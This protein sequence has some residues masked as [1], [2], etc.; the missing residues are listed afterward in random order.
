MNKADLLLEIGCEEIPARFVEG[1]RSQLAEKTKEWLQEN[2]IQH[3]E[4]KTYA[5]PRRL[6]VYVEQVATQQPDKEEEVRGPAKRIALSEQGEWSKAAQGFARKQ[7]IEPSAFTFK[8]FKGETYVYAEVHQQG[9]QTHVLLNAGVRQI[10]EGLHF[11]KTMRWGDRRMRFIRP[12][13]WLVCMLGEEVIAAEWADCTATNQTKGHR[14][15]GTATALN[16]PRE[17]VERLRQQWVVVDVEERRSLIEKQLRQ[18]ESEQGWHIPV[19]KGLLEEV[20]HLVEYPTALFGRYDESFLN[21][22]KEVLI[23]TMR[24]HQRYFPVETEDGH[25][26]PY[27]VTI[28]NGDDTSLDIV[29]RGNEKVLRARL[30][31]AQFFYEEDQKMSIEAGVEKLSQVVF[32]E[33][34]GTIGDK[35]KRIQQISAELAK[36]MQMDEKVQA[37]LARAAAI[38]KFD[39][40]TL[41]IGEFPELEGLMGEDYARK[42]GEEAEVAQAIREHYLPRAAGDDLPESKIAALIGLADRM[43]TI[44]A[45]FGIGLQPTGSQ[46]PY[47][48]RRRAAGVIQLLLDL[49]SF[50]LSLRQLN[51]VAIKTLVQHNLLQVPVTE[52]KTQIH[53]FFSARQKTVLQDEHIRYDVIEAVLQS[54]IC[55]PG[56][57]RAKAHILMQEVKQP[58]FKEVIEG[59]TRAANL[60]AK[61]ESG[62]KVDKSL[63]F[64]ASEQE[65]YDAY[66]K[67]KADYVIQAGTRDAGQMYASLTHIVPV[68]HRFFDNVLV[69]A[70]NETIRTNRLALLVEITQL[71]SQFARFDQ[72]VTN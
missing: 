60:A 59:F 65:L 45:C 14:F 11:P 67:A 62:V 53:A 20:T 32:H 56:L 16:H 17:Y 57:V 64:E 52:L 21:L 9:E 46:D 29:A 7:G 71:V 13:K 30:Q 70:D 72:L 63:L 48:L 39:L 66:L 36:A 44:V 8:E 2:R 58:A 5:T 43:D 40:P 61:A 22:P 6:A 15:L 49:D 23:T 51:G 18:L 27:F 42:A 50:H 54:D 25:L 4:I 68:I 26:L 38:C 31:D 3:G 34:L 37:Q 33:E 41:M 55:D 12:I 28:R 19:D 10:C 47:G 1:A 69:M 24:E 35:V